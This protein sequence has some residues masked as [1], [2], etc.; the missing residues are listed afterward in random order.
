MIWNLYQFWY[1]TS[2]ACPILDPSVDEMEKYAYLKGSWI[3][4]LL[5]LFWRLEDA[6]HKNKV[7]E[8]VISIGNW[9]TFPPEDLNISHYFLWKDSIS[10]ADYFYTIQW[11]ITRRNYFSQKMEL[12]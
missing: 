3:C 7:W 6:E 4:L 11:S 12:L 8:K 5:N 9:S 2:N 10:I 1:P